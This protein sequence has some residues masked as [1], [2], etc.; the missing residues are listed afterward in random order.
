MTWVNWNVALFHRK[1]VMELEI[2]SDGQTEAVLTNTNFDNKSKTS[3][4]FKNNT[5]EII[6]IYYL[7][8]ISPINVLLDYIYIYVMKC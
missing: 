5:M 1:C 8:L 6:N 7:I 2:I 4:N 3:T